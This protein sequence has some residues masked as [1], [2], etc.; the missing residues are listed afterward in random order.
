MLFRTE[1]LI[2][3][4]WRATDREAFAQMN[5]DPR[6]MEHFPEVLSRQ[7]SD[8]LSARIHAHFALHGYGLWALE[9]QASGAFVGFT[10]L[11]QAT[12]NAHFTPC[13]EIGW[14]LAF[15]AWGQ[16]YAIEAAERC[17]DFAF[18]EL[19]LDEIVSFT[20]IDNLRSR[21]VME[22]LGMSHNASD[23]FDHPLLPPGHP[24]RRHVL[25]RLSAPGAA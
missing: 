22:R 16:G 18:D 12:F 17:V 14:R 25:Y 6:V 5:A 23:D 21:R 15:E 8:A 4:P 7:E 19:D 20:S 13:V 10:G 1:R 3:R 11:N 2:L 24:L 9:E